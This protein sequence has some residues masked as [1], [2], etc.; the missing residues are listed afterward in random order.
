MRPIFLLLY[1][2]PKQCAIYDLSQYNSSVLIKLE[3]NC[4][5]RFEMSARSVIPI[6]KFS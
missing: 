2:Q 1:L 3:S 6:T 4:N 5:L